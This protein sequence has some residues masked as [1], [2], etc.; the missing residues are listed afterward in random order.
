VRTFSAVAVLVAVTAAAPGLHADEYEPTVLAAAPPTF[1]GAY[2]GLN[3][4]AAWGSLGYATDPGCPPDAVE[5]VFCN[6]SPPS[7]SNG[8]A[9]A[10]SGSGTLSRS[11]FTGGIQGGYNWQAGNLVFGGEGDF[12][13][14]SLSKSVNPT[15]VFPFAFAGTTYALSESMSTDW[16]ITLRGRLGMTVMPQLLLYA[17]AGVALTD[18]RVSSGYADNAIDP[19]QSL[20]G[21]T[22]SS[23]VSN[24]RTGWTI[25]GGGEW[26][27]DSRWSVKAEYLYVDFGSANF[28]VATSNT[29]EFQQTMTIDAD[30]SAQV[31]RVGV[32]YRP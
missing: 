15:G 4:G 17:T 27:I 21:G 11:G 26:M 30:L 32:N 9:V 23:S 29:E 2:I 6:N 24:V 1:A 31:A 8:A 13:A 5:A 25:G 28:A 22:G 10:N 14:F 3:A 18:L 20:P 19:L 7:A 12:G 16:L